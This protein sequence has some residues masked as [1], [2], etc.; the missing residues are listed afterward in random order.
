MLIFTFFNIAPV[1]TCVPK[2]CGEKPKVNINQQVSGDKTTTF[3]S[4]LLYKC[5]HGYYPTESFVVQCTSEGFFNLK[6]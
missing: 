6:N 2:N 4:K 5:E 3:G 1:P